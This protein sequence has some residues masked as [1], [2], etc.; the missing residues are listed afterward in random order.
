MTL[1]D[2]GTDW[3]TKTQIGTTWRMVGGGAIRGGEGELS[4]GEQVNFHWRWRRRGMILIKCSDCFARIL[5]MWILCWFNVYSTR[6][7]ATDWSTEA[8]PRDALREFYKQRLNV[9]N[10]YLQCISRW[11]NMPAFLS[12][13]L[14]N[15]LNWS[16]NLKYCLQLQFVSFNKI[17]NINK[18]LSIIWMLCAKIVIRFLGTLQW[19]SFV[20]LYPTAFAH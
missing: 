19:L 12:L 11:F 7:A 1:R 16:I 18:M 13:E 8:V 10:M 6:C 3:S 9:R 4:L 15:I 5:V 14:G 17:I 2:T 20:W